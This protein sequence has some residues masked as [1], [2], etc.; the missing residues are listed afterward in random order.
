MNKTQFLALNFVGGICALLILCNLALGWLNGG[1]NRSVAETQR[2]FNQAQQ[3]QNTAQNLVLRVAQA[4]QSDPVL[5]GLLA[6]YE[7]G[8]K[9]NTNNPPRHAP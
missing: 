9:F 3:I 6:K 1:L 8:V 4:G 7:F 2:Q 5:Q